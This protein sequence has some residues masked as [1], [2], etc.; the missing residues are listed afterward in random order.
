MKQSKLS[1]NT[2]LALILTIITIF[3]WIAVDVYKIMAKKEIPAVL[4]EQLEPLNTNLET[5]ILETLSTKKSYT[6]EDLGQT[7]NNPT[8]V[9]TTSGNR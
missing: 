2:V 7:L 4:K 5:E 6:V 3:V 1:R 8:P 9:G